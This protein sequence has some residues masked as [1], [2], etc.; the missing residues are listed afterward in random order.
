MRGVVVLALDI[1]ERIVA[2]HA[3][4]GVA[5]D[6]AGFDCAGLSA[7]LPPRGVGAPE[8]VQTHVVEIEA[9]MVLGRI[10][11]LTCARRQLQRLL[12]P[13]GA[14]V[15]RLD[16]GRYNRLAPGLSRPGL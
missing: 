7:A 6:L 10:L 13:K 1:D 15:A 3:H 14:R 9:G 8:G 4:R 16:D 11:G 12:I 5:G 2:G